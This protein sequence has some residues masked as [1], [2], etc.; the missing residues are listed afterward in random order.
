MKELNQSQKFIKKFGHHDLE[1]EVGKL[2]KQ[3]HGAVTVRYGDTVILAT[4]VTAEEP[5]EGNVYFPMLVD[6]EEKLYAAG[7]ISGSRF[8]KREGRPSDEAFLKARLVDRSLRPLFP[9]NYRNDLQII[10][11]VLS[12]DR[13]TDPGFLAII[14]ASTAL[15]LTSSPF[16]GPVGAA[17]VGIIDG[18]VVV[19]PLEDEMEKSDLDFVVAG[20][21]NKVVMVEGD[22]QEVA[23]D[24]VLEAIEFA[25][26]NLQVACEIQNEIKS[27]LGAKEIEKV[28]EEP[29]VFKAVRDKIGKDLEKI[30]K[31]SKKEDREEKLSEIKEKLLLEMEGDFKQADLSEA[32]DKLIEKEVRREILDENSRPDGRGENEIRPIS[33]EVGV[34][35]RVHGSG[36]FTRG[37]TQV[38]TA[39][40]LGAPGQEQVIETMEIETTKRYMHHY[41]F[42]PYSVGEI[43]PMRGPGRRDIGHGALAERALEPVI[44]GKEDFPYTI[45]VVSEVLES[46]GSSSMAAVCGST[47]SLMDAGVPVTAPVAGIAIGLI[48]ENADGSTKGKYRIL[49]DIQGIEDFAGE[50]DFKIAGTSKGI[51]AVQLDIKTY[52]VD[53]KILKEALK[54]A[55]TARLE[56]LKAMAKTI[57]EPRRELSRYAPRITVMHINPE[58]IKDVIGPGGKV[59]NKIIAETNV[60]IDIEDD[61]TVFISAENGGDGAK[62]AT[63]WIQNLTREVKI[64]EIFQGRVTRI[65]DFGAFV[66]ILPNQEGLVHISQL[67]DRHVK[68]VTDVVKVGDII[69][70]MVIEIDPQGRINLSYKAAKGKDRKDGIKKDRFFQK[71][72]F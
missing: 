70:V 40:T 18:K 51:T 13:Q 72:H 16:A 23:E 60:E 42:P 26:K 44:P 15:S 2:A 62:K 20:T 64:G 32:F 59:I 14:A 8:I 33:S 69:P 56:I 10:V 17:R 54:K 49:T 67:D 39:T 6:Y 65:M 28:D 58:K 4:V 19:N 43:S 21:K 47:L 9:K 1:I 24:K 35:P 50:M 29:E 7:K 34:L 53:H 22:A 46:N 63:E 55:K 48:T 57:A 31:T 45:R 5:A 41:N 3:A 61:G 38:L 30:I 52:G 68:K 71:R 37:Q 11:T 12:L 27:K 36:L 66:E 25:Q